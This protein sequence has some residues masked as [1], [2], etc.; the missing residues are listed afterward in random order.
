[1]VE[2]KFNVDW[3]WFR[4]RREAIDV[5]F[6]QNEMARRLAIDEGTMSKIIG[7]HQKATIQQAVNLALILRATLPEVLEKLGYDLRGVL[8]K[9]EA[10][11]LDERK[12]GALL[13]KGVEGEG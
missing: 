11:G 10:G 9:A 3:R 1:M 4:D 13:K 2:E 6:S 7:G 8:T 12:R 5:G